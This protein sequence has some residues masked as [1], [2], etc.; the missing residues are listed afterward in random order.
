MTNDTLLEKSYVLLLESPKMDFFAKYS[1]KV[2]MFAK[3]NFQ[4]NLKYIF[5]KSHFKCAQNFTKF[6]KA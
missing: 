5:L 4:K 1:Y 2:K 3:N 6:S